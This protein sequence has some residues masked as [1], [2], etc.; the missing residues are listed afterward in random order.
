MAA[1][2]TYITTGDSYIDGILKNLKWADPD[3]TFSFPTSAS[4]Y[5]AG[6]G[7]GETSSNFM[8]LNTAQ[9]AAVRAALDAYASVADL[10]FTELTGAS[11]ASATLRF[12][13]SDLP[14]TAWAYGP[15]THDEGGDVWLNRSNG[16]YMSPDKGDYSSLAIM[17]EIGHALGLAHPHEGYVMP[18]GR[19]AMEYTVMSYRSYVGAPTTGF[20]NETAGYA[21]SPM[22]YDIA[23]L[24]HIYG[25]NYGT[26]SGDTLYTWRPSTGEMLID[27]IGQG[28][29]EAN[30]IFQT[31]WDGGG[32]DTY[33]FSAYGTD[34]KVDLR[35]GEWTT[36][37]TAQL[38][39]L[40]QNGSKL[41][42]G[43]IANALL[44]DNDPRSLIENA[45]G[46]SGDDIMIGNDADNRLTGGLG[47]DVMDGGAGWDAAD[48]SDADPISSSQGGRLVAD[49]MTSGSNNGEATGDRYHSIEE[50]IGSRHNDSLRGDDDD[51][52]VRGGAGHDE[53]HGRGGDDA[54][55]GGDGNDSFSGGLGADHL[56]GGS[57]QDTA[58]YVTAEATDA[59]GTG[60]TVDLIDFGANTGEA[61][62]DSY[63]SI[64]NVMGSNYHDIIRG[65][66]AANGIRGNG[67]DDLIDGRGGD[68]SLLGCDGDDILIGGLGADTLNG[69]AGADVFA[70]LSAAESTAAK[71]DTITGFTSGED[72][73]D[74]TAIDANST[75]S[76]NQAF[77]F[78]GDQAFSGAAA[79]LRFL[80]MILSGD[81]DGD[82][83]ADMS[84]KLSGVSSLA[85]GDILL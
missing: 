20:T 46:G 56:D 10:S 39:K 33:D 82:G 37:S 7:E 40:H 74:L 1:V 42:P 81:I 41:A 18:T 64:E 52:I 22:M 57:G 4:A 62:G 85:A 80:N 66:D 67:G 61:E 54:L 75:A 72:R 69:G 43:N 17:H 31:V 55:Y 77:S 6:Y 34:L 48:Y 84:I 28:R 14:P 30:R 83:V 44:H 2:S 71:R 24:Q 50:L 76:G 26:N 68:D 32:S 23:A 12:G 58:R 78:I 36:V 47:A 11:A 3:L 79:E 45:V 29:P 21:Q 13:V 9:Q 70:Y 51:N 15:S 19:D 5:G 53:L 65:T 73:I 35:P 49:L 27:G 25:A 63:H 59:F 38:A 16:Y 60:L 8:A